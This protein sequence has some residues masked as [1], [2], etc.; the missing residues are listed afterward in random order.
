M[1]QYINLLDLISFV[2]FG[3]SNK[4]FKDDEKRLLEPQLTALGYYDFYWSTG[5]VDS[6]GPLSRIVDMRDNK[7]KLVHG[8]YA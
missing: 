6:F 3:W 8:F 1:K 7:G 5:E 4:T 2:G